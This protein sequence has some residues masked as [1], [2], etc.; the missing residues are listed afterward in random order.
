MSSTEAQ[1]GFGRV[2]EIV[3]RNATVFITRR[4]ANQAVILSVDRYEEL[5]GQTPSDLDTLTA[6]FDEMVA[7]MQTPAAKAA[8][9]AAFRASPDELAD[10][11]VWAA[12]RKP[13]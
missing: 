3:G 6:E 13:A 12:E 2:L 1:N 5:T 4:N 10:A 8:M 7:Q 11:A 9:R